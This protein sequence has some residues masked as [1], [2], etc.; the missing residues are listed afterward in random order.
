MD[1]QGPL[2]RTI[3][4]EPL[5]PRL[6]VGPQGPLLKTHVIIEAQASEPSGALES[7][8]LLLKIIYYQG[9]P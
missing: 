4:L 1:P 3:T 9:P 7:I 6:S 5:E 2:L 8:G